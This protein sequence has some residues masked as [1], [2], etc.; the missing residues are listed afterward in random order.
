MHFGS[1]VLRLAAFVTVEGQQVKAF[2]FPEWSVAPPPEYHN[3]DTHRDICHQPLPSPH[4]TLLT[5]TISPFCAEISKDQKWRSKKYM[6]LFYVFTHQP[7]TTHLRPICTIPAHTTPPL[8]PLPT[9]FT[10]NKHLFMTYAKP[11]YASIL[12]AQP[13]AKISIFPNSITAN[14]TAFYF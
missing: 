2:I 8:P 4:T 13:W 3:A 7:L 11:T 12:L 10:L 6:D 9:H 1:T 14:P 5:Q